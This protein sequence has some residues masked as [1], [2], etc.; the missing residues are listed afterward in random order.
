MLLR[1]TAAAAPL[2]LR[3]ASSSSS[4]SAGAVMSGEDSASSAIHRLRGCNGIVFDLDNTLVTSPLDFKAMRRALMDAFGFGDS[5]KEDILLELEAL[6]PDAKASALDI[7]RNMEIEAAKAMTMVP[8]ASELMRQLDAKHVSRALL[9]RN[10]DEAVGLFH[11]LIGAEPIALPPMSVA[12]SRDTLPL[13]CV[14]PRPDG[15][16][17]ICEQWGFDPSSVAM[18]GDSLYNDIQSG[19]SAGCSVTVYVGPDRPNSAVQADIRVDS[20]HELA[21][22]LLA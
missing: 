9:T 20:L 7:I 22:M 12:V 11:D 15:V 13:Q 19:K 1:R 3:R 6:D 5:N 16:L 14:K 8:G 10:C 18:V 17:H 2:V 4:S 21:A